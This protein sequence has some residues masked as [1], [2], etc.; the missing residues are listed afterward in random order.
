MNALVLHFERTLNISRNEAIV[1]V[2]MVACL[3]IAFLLIVILNVIIFSSLP[4]YGQ[5]E[6]KLIP[7]QNYT[8][9]E[10]ILEGQIYL[11]ESDFVRKSIGHKVFV[12]CMIH[13]RGN[14]VVRYM[15]RGSDEIAYVHDQKHVIA[16]WALM[17]PIDFS[18]KDKSVLVETSRGSMIVIFLSLIAI[19]FLFAI[20]S[21]MVNKP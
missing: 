16:N 15:T 13:E 9:V 4:N 8:Q 5:E 19:L 6:F 18:I 2:V 11:N 1:R 17:T 3:A 10:R 21:S 12:A 20:Y 7:V 14:V